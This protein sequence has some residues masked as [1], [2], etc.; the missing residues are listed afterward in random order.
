MANNN[1]DQVV[2]VQISRD[3]VALDEADFNTLLFITN[4]QVFSERSRKYYSADQLIEDGFDSSGA[5]YAAALAYFSQSPKPTQMVIGKR[6]ATAQTLE[7]TDAEVKNFQT[8]TITVSDGA[9][10]ET[11]T[12]TTGGTAEDDIAVGRTSIMDGLDTDMTANVTLVSQTLASDEISFTVPAGLTITLSNISVKLDAG[13]Y[14]DIAVMITAQMAYD[15]LWYTV[16][17]Y[18]HIEADVL[19]MAVVIEAEYKLYVTS[20]QAS[21]AL[22]AIPEG[23]VAASDDIPGK[24]EELNYDRT[25]CFYNAAADSK[26][27]EVA[28]AGKKLTAVP[29]AT[30]WMYTLLAGQA[31]DNLSPSQSVIL[32]GKNCNTYED[33]AGTD[34]IREGTVASGEF[35]DVMRGSDELR[36]RIQIEVF[37]ALVVAA[38]G[39]SKISLTDDGVAQLTAIV[40]TELRRSAENDFIQ[41]L[42]DVKDSAGKIKSVAGYVVEASLVSS[43]PANQRA[44]RQAPD[45]RFAAV[46]AGAI[47]KVVVRGNLTV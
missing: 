32:L 16:S 4:E 18:S 22:V 14:E 25:A 37:R 31:S 6:T 39:G 1:I 12:F 29:G 33:F 15:N 34:M 27:I 30:T 13:T 40:E 20:T 38:N 43:L 8:Y 36:N 2:D 11:A 5:A 3:T 35:I 45:I 24:L 26:F 28:V 23:Q 46:L 19:A 44:L 21:E 10:S 42:V 17:M 9:T 7:V 47:H 41:E